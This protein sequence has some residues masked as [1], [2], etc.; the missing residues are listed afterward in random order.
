VFP[1]HRIEEIPAAKNVRV[2]LPGL[3]QMFKQQIPVTEY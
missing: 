2:A 1:L 3:F